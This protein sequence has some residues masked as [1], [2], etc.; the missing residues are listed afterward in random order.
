M[1]QKLFHK[2]YCHCVL[3]WLHGQRVHVVYSKGLKENKQGR[4]AQDASSGF[5]R[6]H[7]HRTKPDDNK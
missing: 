2:I 3:S 1:F 6:E 7:L 5:L 4:M